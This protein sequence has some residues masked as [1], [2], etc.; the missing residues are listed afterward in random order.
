MVHQNL[1]ESFCLSMET[2]ISHTKIGDFSSIH[3]LPISQG[4]KQAKV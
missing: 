1:I 2:V 4:N 3:K